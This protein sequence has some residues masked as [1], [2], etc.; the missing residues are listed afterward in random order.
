MSLR[1]LGGM[2]RIAFCSANTDCG[3]S[4]GSRRRHQSIDLEQVVRVL[5]GPDLLRRD[6][7]V[8]L[9]ARVRRLRRRADHAGVHAGAEPIDVGPRPEPVALVQFRGSEAGRV[10]RKQLRR[11]LRQGLARGT[12]VEQHRRAVALQVDIGRLQVQVQQSIGM[13]LPQPVHH[14]G[15]DPPDVTLGHLLL[16][17]DAG[18]APGDCARPRRPSPCRPYRW[19]GRS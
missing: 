9:H 8:L 17:G 19:R 1:F 7:V 4:S 11:V 16:A 15:E 3:R 14:L 12:E 5:A 10:H 2:S 18:S 6:Q 13:D